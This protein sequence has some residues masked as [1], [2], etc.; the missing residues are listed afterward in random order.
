MWT[1][2]HC[3]VTF[4][5]DNRSLK[6]NHSRWC[7]DNPK[8]KD[9]R[10]KARF[11]AM[12]ASNAYK[13]KGVSLETREKLRQHRLGKPS[14]FSGKKHSV[15]SLEKIKIAA[16]N[17]K[18]RRLLRSTQE[19]VKIDGSIVLLDSSWE[20]A[21]AKRLD[22]LDIKWERP[23]EPLEWIDQNN[24]FRNYFPDFYLVD[25]KVYLDPKNNE[26]MRKQKEKIDWILSNRTDVI[27]L[28][29]LEECKNFNPAVV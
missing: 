20:V 3:N 17:S 22:S 11:L 19:Y 6:A 9:F 21:L 5:F 18:H 7:D 4:N 28:L 1:C 13:E 16:N 29:S 8:S 26:A 27:F 25:Y 2:K 23:E 12:N 14:W 24:K 10:E 15:E